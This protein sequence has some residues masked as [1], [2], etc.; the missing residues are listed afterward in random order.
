MDSDEPAKKG[1]RRKGKPP[2][3]QAKHMPGTKVV[4]NPQCVNSGISRLRGT[5]DAGTAALDA[6]S[7]GDGR[8]ANAPLPPTPSGAAFESHAAGLEFLEHSS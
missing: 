3:A 5:L 1:R 4:Q 6:G 7:G 2:P 8:R